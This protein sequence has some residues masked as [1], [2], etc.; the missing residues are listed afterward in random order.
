MGGITCLLLLLW[1]GVT[2]STGL[3]LQKRII[4]GQTCGKDDRLYHVE[5]TITHPNG[6]FHCGGTLIKK[7]WI[8]TAEHCREKGGTITAHVGV[9]P[10]TN[11][12]SVQIITPPEIFTDTNGDIHDIMLLKLPEPPNITP[13]QLPDCE[14]V[15]KIGDTVQMAGHSYTDE[16]QL[17]RS[18]TLQCVDTTVVNC[19]AGFSLA[20]QDV[21]C[22]K[23]ARVDAC[24]GDSGSGVV[25]NGRIYGV[26]SSGACTNQ[27]TQVEF[28]DVCNKDY[29]DWI[30]RIVAT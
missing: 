15:P 30:N 28:M 22:G 26:I 10:G 7:L 11:K 19:V 18:T 4:G 23:R 12:Q 14:N 8:L 27:G 13:V 29:M 20:H 2:V 3:D 17:K 1:A 16:I 6:M 24:P 21:F 25:Y 9:H 5:L